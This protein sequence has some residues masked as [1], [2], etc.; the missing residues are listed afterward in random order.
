MD[1]QPVL[2]VYYPTTAIF[3]DDSDTFLENVIFQL[4]P[5][6]PYKAYQEP[7]KALEYILEKKSLDIRASLKFICNNHPNDVPESGTYSVNYQFSTLYEEIYNPNRFQDLSVAVIDYAMPR[8]NGIELCQAL[9]D[10]PIKKILLT[11][12]ADHDVAINAFNDGIIDKFIRKDKQAAGQMVNKAIFELQKLYFQERTIVMTS[13]LNT[14]KSCFLQDPL[15]HSLFNNV[16]NKTSACDSYLLES[17]GSFLFMGPD[18]IP[19]WLLVKSREDLQE[20]LL[21]A[22]EYDA[23]PQVIKSLAQGTKVPYF[24]DFADYSD[25]MDGNWEKYLHL[26]FDWQESGKYFYAIVKELPYF[27]LK[28]HKITSLHDYL[29]SIN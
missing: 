28:N 17:S 24:K 26:A 9:K 16:L 18:K 22:Q 1:K 5:N 23:S 27:G 4:D 12:E 11:G 6:I 8:I 3:I 21:V 20:Y 13:A 10:T 29:K 19:T 25:A 2:C 14:E 15:Y 7:M